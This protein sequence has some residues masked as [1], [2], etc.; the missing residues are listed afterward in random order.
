MFHFSLHSGTPRIFWQHYRHTTQPPPPLYNWHPLPP[1]HHSH[2]HPTFSTGPTC[3]Y[4]HHLPATPTLR[5]IPHSHTQ[6]NIPLTFHPHHHHKPT[7]LHHQ[8]NLFHTPVH[9]PRSTI[10]IQS[11]RPRRPT[12]SVSLTAT[13]TRGIWRDP[14]RSFFYL[15]STAP[16]ATS[17]TTSRSR[18]RSPQQTPGTSTT[19]HATAT[20]D[21]ASPSCKTHN[22]TIQLRMLFSQLPIPHGRQTQ[23]PGGSHPRA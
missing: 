13:A 8:L 14:H 17:A 22:V 19:I 9:S 3:S 23:G 21:T 15:K 16:S 10:A 5:P 4:S 18:S 1:H 2:H 20:K 11:E 6:Q 7:A 12:P